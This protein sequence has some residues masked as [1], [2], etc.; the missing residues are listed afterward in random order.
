MI[1]LNDN[2]VSFIEHT[3]SE[4]HR[5]HWILHKGRSSGFHIASFDRQ[6]QLDLFA[7]TLGF[8]YELVEERTWRGT[9]T[10]YKEFS[11]SKNIVEP[12]SYGGFWT[13]EEL[14]EGV[15]PIKALSNGS[16]VTCYFRTLKDKIEFFRPNPNAKDVYKPLEIEQHIVHKKIYGV[17]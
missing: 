17:Y 10:K 6:D 5:Y 3:D 2:Y 14:P 9:N 16:I 4:F 13:I 8:S 11:V 12:L 15:K 1:G 7:Q